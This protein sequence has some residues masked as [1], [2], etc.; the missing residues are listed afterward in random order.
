VAIL[1]ANLVCLPSSS[2]SSLVLIMTD[3]ALQ[4]IKLTSEDDKELFDLVRQWFETRKADLDD[5]EPCCA[6]VSR[7]LK[8]FRTKTYVDFTTDAK[9]ISAQPPR[10]GSATK[11][12]KKDTSVAVPV[13]IG[14]D[15]ANVEVNGGDPQQL[16]E[17]STKPEDLAPKTGAK[18]EE[19]RRACASND[20]NIDNLLW[21]VNDL[22]RYLSLL[23]CPLV[24][25]ENEEEGESKL[26]VADIATQVLVYLE[27]E[28]GTTDD[29]YLSVV[30]HDVD[31][32]PPASR[33]GVD[34]TQGYSVQQIR[35]E[36]Y[37][38]ENL[39]PVV[40]NVHRG[41]RTF[42]LRAL[43]SLQHTATSSVESFHDFEYLWASCGKSEDFTKSITNLLCS[44]TSNLNNCN[45]KRP[46]EDGFVVLSQDESKACAWKISCLS[47]QN[48]HLDEIKK[49]EHHDEKAENHR[50][51]RRQRLLN[52]AAAMGLL[53]LLNPVSVNASKNVDIAVSNDANG[54]PVP[55]V[56]H[57]GMHEEGAV[58]ATTDNS[59]V[60]KKARITSSED[61]AITALSMIFSAPQPS[62]SPDSSQ[63]RD[64]VDVIVDAANALHSFLSVTNRHLEIG[65]PYARIEVEEKIASIAKSYPIVSCLETDWNEI[66]RALPSY[67]SSI[68]FDDSVSQKLLGQ[69]TSMDL[70]DEAL[71]K[72]HRKKSYNHCDFAFGERLVA[73][74]DDVAFAREPALLEHVCF[75][76][77]KYKSSTDQ[78]DRLVCFILVFDPDDPR[79]SM[80]TETQVAEAIAAL[81]AARSPEAAAQ[82]PST[83]Q[84][85][86]FMQ[87]N[88]W[89]VA[90][91]SAKEIKPSQRLMLYLEASDDEV[92]K[93][94]KAHSLISGIHETRESLGWRA[95]IVTALNRAMYKLTDE[96][97][98]DSPEGNKKLVV[99]PMTGELTFDPIHKSNPD[100]QLCIALVTLYYHA[101][102]CTIFQETARRKTASH[103]KIVQ[104]DSFHRALLSFCYVCL[105]KGFSVSGKLRLEDRHQGLELYHILQMLES[106]PYSYL[107]ASES[108]GL[109]LR[110]DKFRPKTALPFTASLPK[111]LQR[112]ISLCE[113]IIVDSH[114]WSRDENLTLEGCVMDAIHEIKLLP[115]PESDITGVMWP[116]EGLK[117]TL[118]EE[119]DDYFDPKKGKKAPKPKTAP[120]PKIVIDPEHRF[121]A[122]VIRKLL[123]IMYF[124]IAGL[125]SAL[126]IPKSYPIAGQIWIA[127]RYLVRHHVEL[128]YDRHVDQLLLCVLYGVCKIMRY[129][130]ELSFSTIIDGYTEI[131]S[132][133][134]GDRGCQRVVRQIRIVREGDIDQ[135]PDGKP[136]KGKGFG[137]VIH[138]YNQAFVP[139][140]K[141]HLLQSKSL[142]KASLKLRRLL[143]EKRSAAAFKKAKD[144]VAPAAPL[145]TSKARVRP[146]P[147]PP[148][149]PAIPPP[150]LPCAIPVQKGN[151]T[152][153]IRLVSTPGEALLA[154]VGGQPRF[155][156]DAPA[157]NRNLAFVA[158]TSPTS[159]KVKTRAFF[160]FGDSSKQDIER[161]NRMVTKWTA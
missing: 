24:I 28:T 16:T 44:C 90:I 43:Q 97:A 96:D 89:C 125:C 139:A 98:I 63:D 19:T 113:I 35:A 103:P 64:A 153:N 71:D 37:G 129:E 10:K 26:T 156:G 141:N 111:I 112:H 22:A 53:S 45:G 4:A 18:T 143:A 109:A 87:L 150:P 155:T 147:S 102:E 21:L 74:V 119:K 76:S 30:L 120:R 3:Q 88:E 54:K 138:L 70:L 100:L 148:L 47:S 131:R 60:A 80:S 41:F 126:H 94:S 7:L 91:L 159:A 49:S 104:N 116:P 146:G 9:T 61:D 151:V 81:K 122:Y 62:D 25:D 115:K 114:I 128:L 110:F 140:M 121:T 33:L 134:I 154:R 32:T 123:K 48:D 108:V 78:S 75:A 40:P 144:N 65:Q 86:E 72:Q 34:Q 68:Q 93:Q 59:E 84:G 152:L 82:V 29:L 117:P 132:R 27:E 55:I 79:V 5:L 58:G 145:P 158:V 136:P 124:R 161:A 160:A 85:V 38:T 12:I 39:T 42:V 149:P 95:K 130:P 8:S 105:L 31:L 135:A 73:M 137:N 11:E 142:K 51:S 127:F 13:Q 20:E 50:V 67:D 69:F 15:Q 157:D 83:G 17:T 66:A 52:S 57:D 36:I 56:A 77:K 101:L 106:T 6:L 118:P 107:K 14:E 133:E 99:D 2:L 23:P 92:V 1:G 46:R